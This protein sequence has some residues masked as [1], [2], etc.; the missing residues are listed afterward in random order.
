[1][2]VCAFA[3]ADNLIWLLLGAQ[4][5][6]MHKPDLAC[7]SATGFPVRCPAAVNHCET[8]AIRQTR[9]KGTLEFPIVAP[10]AALFSPVF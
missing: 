3:Y 1:M 10:R 7:A 4:R 6:Q 9:E 5:A 2:S 8:V